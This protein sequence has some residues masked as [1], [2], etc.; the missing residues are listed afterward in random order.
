MKH[1]NLPA[2]GLAALA[3]SLGACAAAGAQAPAFTAPDDAQAREAYLAAYK[4]DFL[5]PDS[6]AYLKDVPEDLRATHLG[7]KDPGEREVV[8][9]TLRT[10]SKVKVAG[11]Q[12][13]PFDEA[14]LQDVARPRARDKLTAGYLCDLTDTLTFAG[15]YAHG[16]RPDGDANRQVSTHTGGSWGGE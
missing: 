1:F 8:E 13:A 3:L 12:W 5:G 9:R 10:I 14:V 15:E 7:L 4:A 16:W 6:E 11:C 2:A